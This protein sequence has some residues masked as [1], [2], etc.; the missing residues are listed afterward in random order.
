MIGKLLKAGALAYKVINSDKE[1][2]TYYTYKHNF[3]LFKGMFP[4]IAFDPEVLNSTCEFIRDKRLFRYHST[5]YD[6]SYLDGRVDIAL[7]EKII[8]KH[9]RTCKFIANIRKEKVV[10]VE[11]HAYSPYKIVFDMPKGIRGRVA[12]SKYNRATCEFV[13]NLISSRSLGEDTYKYLSPLFTRISREIFFNIPGHKDLKE[14]VPENARTIFR[15]IENFCS[16]YGKYRNAYL[17][18]VVLVH[19]EAGTGKSW[20]FD[21]LPYLIDNENISFYKNNR[22]E[23]Y[24]NSWRRSFNDKGSSDKKARI[25]P[26]EKGGNLLAEPEFSKME[27]PLSGKGIRVPFEVIDEFDRYLGKYAY[28]GF[29]DDYKGHL[30][31]K[32]KKALEMSTGIIILITNH[33]DK[34][35]ETA[36]RAGRVQDTV[37]I[38][39]DFYNIEEKERIL[40]HYKTFYHV[41]ELI[42]PRS[43][44]G[45][46]S[47][48]EIKNMC[49]RALM[50]KSYKEIEK[51]NWNIHADNTD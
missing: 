9:L 36:I 28:S 24:L 30:I 12:I 40:E 1:A 44:L 23:E 20:M 34:I 22:L 14:L 45:G 16:V 6:F 41:P 29:F 51:I 2:S 5:V 27:K 47:V 26:I 33:V 18:W 17:R 37:E 46:R 38:G 10:V 19:G 11:N 15:K 8:V 13:H 3:T 49:D 21:N 7:A 4:A 48:A 50:E 32:F 25:I 31:T 35:D 43:T 42:V 39:R